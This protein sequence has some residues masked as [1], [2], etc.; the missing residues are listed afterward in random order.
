M[1]KL[2]CQENDLDSAIEILEEIREDKEYPEINQA[3]GM[4]YLRKGRH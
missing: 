1:S 2:Y 4:L 3:L